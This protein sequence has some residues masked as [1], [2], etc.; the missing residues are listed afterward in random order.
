MMDVHWDAERKWNDMFNWNQTGNSLYGIRGIIVEYGGLESV[1]D[2]I[3]RVAA[4]RIINL[5]DRR[6][7]K[8]IVKI[9]SGEQTG[10]KLLA[11]TQLL[12]KL[13]L[14]VSG[15]K[16]GTITYTG[17]GTCDNYLKVI[18]LTTFEHT[19]GL[20]AR[21]ISV[22]IGDVVKPVGS[23][24]YFKKVDDDYLSYQQADYQASYSNLCGLQ[25]YLANVT[26]AEDLTTIA[27]L[28][29]TDGKE[30]WINGTDRCKGGIFRSGFWRYTS[31]PLKDKEFWRLR[32]NYSGPI[33]ADSACNET[34]L[35]QLDNSVRVGPFEDSWSANHPGADD[36]DYLT[37]L[38]GSSPK[39]K[40]RKNASNTNVDS[41]IV[42][43]GGSVGDFTKSD[44]QEDN[45]IQ[46]IAGPLSAE[47]SFYED[48][49]Q[50]SVFINEEDTLKLAGLS[51]GWTSTGYISKEKPLIITAPVN[52]VS[53][54]DDWR[55]ELAK[56][57]YENEDKDD[58][59]P[60]N[61]RIKITLKYAD[62]NFNDTFGIVKNIG[63][64]NKV[65][66]SPFSWSNR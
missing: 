23:N 38:S 8:A 37:I 43:Y 6:I 46:V 45:I 7:S 65:T 61:R 4:K 17:S 25:G 53:S 1:G 58:F 12:T 13:G 34:V 21:E 42:K 59:T 14:T 51:A 22:K 10:D 60:G 26:T 41:Y 24:Y 32:I 66:V 30:A 20:G 36:N 35:R 3:T 40:T 11:P 57:Y 52:K 55:Q 29:V 2:S 5:Y 19:G 33:E 48:G 28:G 9:S 16:T 44:L 62:I 39:I 54:E 56:V 50:N 49:S 18:Q 64:K 47:L 15:N 63:S 31:G 27:S